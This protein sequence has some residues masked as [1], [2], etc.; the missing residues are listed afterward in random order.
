MRSLA[1][2]SVPSRHV[3]FTPESGHSMTSWARPLWANNGHAPI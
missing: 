2:I 1:D 3:R